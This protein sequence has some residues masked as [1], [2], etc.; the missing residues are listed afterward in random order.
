MYLTRLP[1]G[2]RRVL[3]M[4][5]RIIFPDSKH[6][7][8]CCLIRATFQQ[9]SDGSKPYTNS[10]A[11]AMAKAPQ[12]QQFGWGIMLMMSN[13][14]SWLLDF[15]IAQTCFFVLRLTSEVWKLSNTLME[16]V[17][18]PS[19]IST[20]ETVIQW[21]LSCN[22]W[23]NLWRGCTGLYWKCF[24]HCGVC[25]PSISFACCASRTLAA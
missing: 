6:E 12:S 19:W 23:M 25:H 1:K 13:L 4:G 20:F 11:H 5:N 14:T 9:H 21:P 18:P 15:I 3:V 17:T 8:R 2:T 24:P 22:I 16:S 10:V 7:S